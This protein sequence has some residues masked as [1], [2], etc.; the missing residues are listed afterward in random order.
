MKTLDNYII[1]KL[2]INKNVKAIIDTYTFKQDNKLK[3]MVLQLPIKF[4]VY[5]HNKNVTI[6]KIEHKYIDDKYI[7]DYKLD[8]YVFKHDNDKT[9]IK[10]TPTQIYRA[11]LDIASPRL[12]ELIDTIFYISPNTQLNATQT[13]MIKN[14]RDTVLEKPHKYNIKESLDQ[15]EPKK[16]ANVILLS[17]DEDEVLVL[18]RANY[19]QKFKGMYGF[20]GGHIDSKDKNPKEAAIRELKEETGIELTWHEE[21]KMKQYDVI[22]N[23]DAIC[24]YYIT[25][26]EEKPEVKLSKEHSGFEWFNDK[27]KNKN[28]KWMPDVF[29]IIQKVLK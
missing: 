2:H 19:M 26:L 15:D 8:Y 21:Y 17:P 7:D 12:G 20:P 9:F 6:N 27:S 11:F 18:R 28:H 22:R 14:V 23:D 1:E 13:I 5:D 10:L 29:Q 24:Y 3:G 4:Y 25:T 16:Y